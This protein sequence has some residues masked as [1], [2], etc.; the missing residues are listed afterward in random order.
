MP[1]PPMKLTGPSN[2][3]KVFA[4]GTQH[5]GM[6][7]LP[8]SF[9]N[10]DAVVS[11]VRGKVL[12]S[13]STGAGS[14]GPTGFGPAWVRIQSADDASIHTLAHLDPNSPS[15]PLAGTTVDEGEQIGLIARNVTPSKFHSGVPHLHW[16]VSIAPSFET[17]DPLAWL[18]GKSAKGA[19]DSNVWL[20]IMLGIALA[21][22]SERR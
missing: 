14:A 2:F 3:N 7:I 22:S 15:I 1:V 5:K 18:S 17:V 21:L 19:L 12:E 20:W 16:Q 6:D 8:P 9:A 4:D 13:K 10:G 11:P